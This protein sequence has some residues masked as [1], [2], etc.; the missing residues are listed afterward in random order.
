MQAA[1][2]EQFQIQKYVI[3]YLK[4]KNQLLSKEMWESLNTEICKPVLK[5]DFTAHMAKRSTS[6]PQNFE[7]VERPNSWT[8]SR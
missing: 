2:L 6:Q 7:S 3:S 5:L 1:V 8:K 4:R